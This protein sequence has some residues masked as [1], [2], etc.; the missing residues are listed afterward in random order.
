MGMR[1]SA[2]SLYA[3][4]VEARSRCAVSGMAKSAGWWNGWSLILSAGRYRL[5][6]PLTLRG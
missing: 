2:A 6:S 4:G 3:F 5:L 1:P